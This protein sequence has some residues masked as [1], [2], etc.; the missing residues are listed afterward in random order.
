MKALMN[1]YLD[2][3]LTAEQA[4]TFLAA[5]AQDP[6]LEAELRAYEE[7]LAAVATAEPYEP[8]SDFTACVMN[9]I[10]GSAAFAVRPPGHRQRHPRLKRLAWAAGLILVFGLGYLTAVGFRGLHGALPGRTGQNLVRAPAAS[11]ATLPGTFASQTGQLRLVRLVHVPS[12]SRVDQVTVAG[13]FNNWNPDLTPL[14]KEGNVWT[15]QLILQP[16]TY[17]Y[18]FVE[19]GTDW[20]TDPLAL[21]TRDDGFGKK[22]AVLDLTL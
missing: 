17:E 1:R 6:E 13:D 8:A 16:G 22:N 14:R 5:V 3:E 9:R 11:E 18:M 21:Q 7:I 20:I 10:K 12:D 2:G 4:E 19:D 15:V